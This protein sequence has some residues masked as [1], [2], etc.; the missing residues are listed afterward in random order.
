[1]VRDTAAR[2]AADRAPK[3]L[4]AGRPRARRSGSCPTV[5]SRSSSPRWSSSRSPGPASCSR[6]GGPSWPAGV[7]PSARW[8]A[9]PPGSPCRWSRS[10]S[11][12]ARCSS[13]RGGVHRRQAR[14]G[15]L[16]DRA[17]P[18]GHPAPPPDRRRADRPGTRGPAHVVAVPRRRRRRRRAEPQERALLRRVPAAV[19]RPGRARSAPQSSCSAWSSWGSA[20]CSTASGPS[21]PAR[22]APGSP[23]RPGVSPSSAT[24][25]AA[26]RWSASASVSRRLPRDGL[27][28][29]GGDPGVESPGLGLRTSAGAGSGRSARPPPA[30]RPRCARRAGTW[31][32]R[33]RRSPG[34]RTACTP[35][36]TPSPRRRTVH[37][38]SGSTSTT[39]ASKPGARSP[40]L[41]Q[42]EAAGGVPR[43]Q[44]GHR[45]IAAA[46][47]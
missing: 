5:S 27:A 43:R 11:V 3:P 23:A 41:P 39:S 26:C 10:P 42:P 18:A 22:P 32:R 15:G 36:S 44:R 4:D 21:P 25:P 47:A 7:A 35:A 30:R 40:L 14:R 45:P 17:R 19:R 38:V 16:P 24:A 9:T 34:P 46:R 29:A 37:D 33:S 6:S 28:L 1:M 8:W 20:W 2:G 13:V 31:R 12:S